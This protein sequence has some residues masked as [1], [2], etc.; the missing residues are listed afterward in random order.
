MF[1]GS[2]RDGGQGG[3][4]DGATLRRLESGIEGGIHVVRLLWHQHAQEDYSGF[5]LIY[6]RNAFNEEN[7]TSMLLTV[8]NEWTSVE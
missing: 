2:D 1:A 3:L 6:V 5:L 7:R 4:R 8:R